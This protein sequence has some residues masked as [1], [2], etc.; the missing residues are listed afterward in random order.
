MEKNTI[1]VSYQQ[2]IK[3]RHQ[4]VTLEHQISNNRYQPSNSQEN[5]GLDPIALKK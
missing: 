5:L 2:K 1:M 3:R 4:V